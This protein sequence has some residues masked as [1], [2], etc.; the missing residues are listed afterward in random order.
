MGIGPMDVQ[1]A[2]TIWRSIEQQRMDLYDLIKAYNRIKE[3]KIKPKFMEFVQ[4]LSFTL[5]QKS[6]FLFN[7]L[8]EK[9]TLHIKESKIND[10]L[11][12]D[13]LVIQLQLKEF[14]IASLWIKDEP[15]G[16]IIVDNYVTQKPIAEADIRIFNMFVEQAAGAIENSR[17]YEDT[18]IKAH[19][20]TLTSLWN[21]G[22][23]QYKLD[24]ELVKTKAKNQPLSIMMIDLDNFKN[25]NDTYGHIQG[26]SA[27]K[28]ISEFLKE[29]SRKADILCRY[30]GEEFSFILPSTNKEEALRIG[31]RI[32]KSLE[33]KDILGHRFTISIGIS[34]FREDGLN[35]ESLVKKADDALYI[36]KR[37]GRNRVILA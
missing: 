12:D 14:L 21:H 5:S 24:E 4:S 30:G 2:N 34:S 11:K 9:G 16:V 20:D 31:E 22:Y 13:P 15:Q 29:K 25:Y 36:A 18:L 8:W 28:E 19:T 37:A 10:L 1:E 6:G 17:A 3:E 32:R 26:D 33:E 7:A 27:L 23:F 35:K